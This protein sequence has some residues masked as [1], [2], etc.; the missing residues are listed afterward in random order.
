MCA[1]E[2]NEGK[3]RLGKALEGQC[4]DIFG[5]QFFLPDHNLQHGLCLGECLFIVASK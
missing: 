5:D 2:R 4:T 3:V 1:P